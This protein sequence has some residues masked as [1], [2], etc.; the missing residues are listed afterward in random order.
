VAETRKVLTYI[1]NARE[2]GLAVIFITHNVHQV[3]MVADSYTV[4]R[5]GK[6]VGTYFKG[7]LSEDDIAD[8]ITGDRLA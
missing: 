3:Y 5:H 8:L 1:T 2:R 7:Q 4:I 6:N